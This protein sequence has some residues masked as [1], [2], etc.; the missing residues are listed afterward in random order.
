MQENMLL[1]KMKNIKI[2]RE[3]VEIAPTLFRSVCL[4][5]VEL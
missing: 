5:E 2:F 3:L 4:L 1:L